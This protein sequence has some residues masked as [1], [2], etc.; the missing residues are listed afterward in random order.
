MLLITLFCRMLIITLF[1]RCIL[2]ITLFYR[3]MLT[4]TLFCRMLTIT[5]GFKLDLLC[6]WACVI[7]QVE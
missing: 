1:C 5:L 7:G 6:D 4:I 2:I 3:R